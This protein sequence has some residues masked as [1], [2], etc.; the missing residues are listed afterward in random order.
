MSAQSDLTSLLN[1]TI[2]ARSDVD[3]VTLDGT[4]AIPAGTLADGNSIQFDSTTLDLM[5]RIHGIF[6][7][8]AFGTIVSQVAPGGARRKRGTARARHQSGRFLIPEISP[9]LSRGPVVASTGLPP[10]AALAHPNSGLPP[11]NWAAIIGAMQGAN[12][13]KDITESTQTLT[14]SQNVADTVSAI[15]TGAGALNSILVDSTKFGVVATFVSTLNISAHCWGDVLYWAYDEATGDQAGA[16]S[17]VQDMQSIPLKQE[18]QAIQ[19]LAMAPF[20]ALSGASTVL[21]FVE[22]FGKYATPD[23]NGNSSVNNDYQTQLS[24]VT[25]DA[26]LAASPTTGLAEIDGTVDVTTNLGLEAPDSGVDLMPGPDG[27]NIATLADPSGNYD[28]LIPMGV[29]GFDYSNS[30]LTI[31]DPISGITSGSELVNLSG[32]SPSL[33]LLVPTMTGSCSDD[34]AN[35]PDSDDP[36]CD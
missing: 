31:T 21:N 12:N 13:L 5:D 1:A 2:Q 36:D 35:D 33:P 22:N 15:G 34:D 27:E 11:L 9:A 24:I 14:N 10:H 19:N 16:A 18:L 7:S 26:A 29:S 28:L 30:Q 23:S 20:E 3:R 17:A 8:G 4:V 6:L 25:S 32:A